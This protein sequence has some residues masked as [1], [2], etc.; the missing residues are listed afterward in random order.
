MIPVEERVL[1]ITIIIKL[2]SISCYAQVIT[3]LQGRELTDKESSFPP[4]IQC[5]LMAYPDQIKYAKQHESVWT[6]HWQDRFA[7]QLHGHPMPMFTEK[8]W[9]DFQ[10][11]KQITV[12]DPSNFWTQFIHRYPVNQPI[13]QNIEEGFDPGRHRYEPFFKRL[14]GEDARSVRA[15]TRLIQWGNKKLRVSTINQ[16]DQ[17]LQMIYH[18][19]NGL[20]RKLHRY[21]TPHSGGFVWRNIKGTN[22]L[23]VHS[24]G[25]AIDIAV[26]YSNYWKWGQKSRA[27]LIFYQNQIPIDVVRIFEKYGFIWGGRWYHHDTMHFEYRPV[28]L[29]EPCA[30][31]MP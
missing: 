4:A 27:N 22:R 8:Q 20:P 1:L 30:D 10:E 11:S 14:Y 9:A 7:M 19:L 17:R 25:A 21:F 29:M 24:F 16:I 23:S 31:R 26:K 2:V 13:P 3:E 28:L 18:E 6:L 12:N 5:I 15:Q